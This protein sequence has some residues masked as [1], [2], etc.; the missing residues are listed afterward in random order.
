[1]YETIGKF[2]QHVR[3]KARQ[4]KNSKKQKSITAFR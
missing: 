2:N 1:M 3:K 4:R